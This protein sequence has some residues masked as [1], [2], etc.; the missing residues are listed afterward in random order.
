MG[1]FVDIP[2]LNGS[3]DITVDSSMSAGQQLRV[4]MEIGAEATWIKWRDQNIFYGDVSSGKFTEAYVGKKY[5]IKGYELY[6]FRQW[7]MNPKTSTQLVAGA[8]NS[9]IKILDNS[10]NKIGTSTASFEF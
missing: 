3:F 9:G 10:K 6:D 4:G 8:W 1:E 7:C 5:L 2:T